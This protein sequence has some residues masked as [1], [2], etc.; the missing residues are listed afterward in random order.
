MAGWRDGLAETVNELALAGAPLAASVNGTAMARV[1]SSAISRRSVRAR[2][3]P[4]AAA[5]AEW[6]RSLVRLVIALSDIS[7]PSVCFAQIRRSLQR[8]GTGKAGR[9]RIVT[10]SRV[11]VA[12]ADGGL[13]P[14]QPSWHRVLRLIPIKFEDPSAGSVP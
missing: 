12:E 2:W 3:P 1:A 13:M 6:E 14:A 10:T 4:G 9:D 7:L 5:D 8:Q 11:G